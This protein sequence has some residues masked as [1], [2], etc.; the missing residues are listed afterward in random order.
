VFYGDG[1]RLDVLRAAGAANASLI[2]LCV[3][4]GDASAKIVDLAQTHFPLAKL[5]VRAYDRRQA[6][7]LLRRNVDYQIRETYESAIAFGLAALEALGF[8]HDQTV[9]VEADIRRRDAERMALQMAEGEVLAGRNLM[10]TKVV[11][12]EPLVQPKH[13]AKALNP[14]AEQ[15]TKPE[16]AETTSG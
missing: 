12:P 15:A 16:S 3:A 11:V 5:Y 13:T 8:T 14:E 10:H 6:L 9:E 2:A 7:Q 1:T 4:K